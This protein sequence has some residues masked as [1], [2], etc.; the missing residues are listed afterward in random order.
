MS[1]LQQSLFKKSSKTF[2]YSTLF[3]PR[4]LRPDVYKLYAFVRTADDLVDTLPQDREAFYQFKNASLLSIDTQ[5]LE[6]PDP[7]IAWFIWVYRKYNFKKEWVESFLEAMESDLSTVSM[8]DKQG[9]EQYMYGSAAV[10]WYMMCALF[11]IYDSES[12]YAAKMLAYSMQSINFIR[13]I[14]EDNMLGRKYLYDISGIQYDWLITHD[15]NLHAFI[16]S[17][18]Q[19]YYGYLREAE[20]WLHS[21]P[22]SFRVPVLTASDMY[23]WTAKKIEKNPSIIFQKKVKPSKIQIIRHALYTLIVEW[24]RLPR[25]SQS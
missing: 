6:S 2:Y 19:N 25:S 3:F 7:I 18:M 10:V 24:A 17:H 12:L 21:L 8:S 13:D 4:N 1:T 5:D 14:D 16:Y 23:R 11:S 15:E 20:D 22:L 9:L